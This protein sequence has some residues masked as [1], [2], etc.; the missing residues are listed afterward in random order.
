MR[1]YIYSLLTVM[2][3]IL[4]RIS[5]WLYPHE[6][7]WTIPERVCY[8]GY[9]ESPDGVLGKVA[10]ISCCDCGASH[11]FWKANDGIYGVPVRPGGYNYRLRLKAEVAFADA[12]A[13][14]KW[15]R[16]R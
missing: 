6:L 8:C 1:L 16:N 12:E 14:G 2:I 13:Q 9:E 4:G 3:Q 15:D 10:H 5:T 11:F 7:R